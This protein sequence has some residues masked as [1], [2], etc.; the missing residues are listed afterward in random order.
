MDSQLRPGRGSN[1]S[2][3]VGGKNAKVLKKGDKNFFPLSIVTAH[4]VALKILE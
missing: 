3:K 1:V 4:H 2:D